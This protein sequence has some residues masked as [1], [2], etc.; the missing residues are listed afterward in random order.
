VATKTIVRW[1]PPNELYAA[2]ELL[3]ASLE[4]VGIFT[5]SAPLVWRRENGFWLDADEA[6]ISPDL[7]N[8]LEEEP[9]SG[10]DLGQ[11]RVERQEVAK[12]TSKAQPAPKE[13]GN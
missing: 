4:L 1:E 11:F 10:G 12:A 13:G 9:F 8:R 3:P 5:Q 7:L 2:R 6:G